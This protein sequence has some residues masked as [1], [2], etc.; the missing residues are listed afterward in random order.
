MA[1][2]LTTDESGSSPRK[3]LDPAKRPED[4]I[5]SMSANLLFP[6]ESKCSFADCTQKGVSSGPAAASS[7]LRSVT[8]L[9]LR[10]KGSRSRGLR[11]T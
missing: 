5:G 3:L 4:D 9:F 8:A 10:E 1:R 2:M 7:V 11:L 6:P